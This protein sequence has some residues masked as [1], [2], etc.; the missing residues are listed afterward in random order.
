MIDNLAS[1]KIK[2]GAPSL[3]AGISLIYNRGAKAYSLP[4]SG[5][6]NSIFL[7]QKRHCGPS[8]CRNTVYTAEVTESARGVLHFGAVAKAKSHY[9]FVEIPQ[10]WLLVSQA[11]RSGVILR[12]DSASGKY[13]YFI[14][15]S[16]G[17][18]IFLYPPGGG[19]FFVSF[20]RGE[21]FIEEVE[22][23]EEVA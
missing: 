16:E 10:K 18:S 14:E 13:R 9:L 8:P 1:L 12:E 5:R 19:K 2:N 23:E 7:S 3:E 21:Y 6:G 22:I 20:F 15:I 11:S 4:F 17:V